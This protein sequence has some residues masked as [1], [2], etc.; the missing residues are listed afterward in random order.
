MPGENC[1]GTHLEI[2]NRFHGSP[3]E[4]VGFLD[5]RSSQDLFP[6]NKIE[7]DVGRHYEEGMSFKNKIKVQFVTI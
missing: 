4:I 5:P 2:Y 3:T 7:R 1:E 6:V